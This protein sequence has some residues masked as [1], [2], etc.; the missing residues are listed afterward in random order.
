MNQEERDASHVEMVELQRISNKL[1]KIIVIIG[2]IT[3]TLGVI[4]IVRS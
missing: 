4:R 1:N 3:I 2:L